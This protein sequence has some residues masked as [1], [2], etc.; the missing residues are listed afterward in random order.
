MDWT[1]LG[2]SFGAACGLV[3]CAVV[4]VW[5]YCWLGQRAATLVF[6]IIVVLAVFTA[7]FYITT[8]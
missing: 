5:V 7:L 8:P 4:A 3:A 1:K 2:I 6:S